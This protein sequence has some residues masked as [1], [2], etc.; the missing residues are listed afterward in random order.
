MSTLNYSEN[1]EKFDESWSSLEISANNIQRRDKI[2]FA[3]CYKMFFSPIFPF[4]FTST[5]M[6]T[7]FSHVNLAQ[8]SQFLNCNWKI[9]SQ[10]FILAGVF[11]L[12]FGDLLLP[13]RLWLLW[14]LSQGEYLHQHGHCSVFGFLCLNDMWALF[15]RN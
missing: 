2:I 13:L 10:N 6:Q 9:Q 8:P 5:L 1:Y 15:H 14:R 11:T 4:L 12:Y 3:V 7:I